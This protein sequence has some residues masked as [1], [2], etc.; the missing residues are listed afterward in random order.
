MSQSYIT[1]ITQIYITQV[2]YTNFKFCKNVTVHSLVVLYKHLQSVLSSTL[3]L[4]GELCLDQ[5][6]TV[7]KCLHS[8]N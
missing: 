3:H 8:A 4:I 5:M 6:S 7:C 1:Q 2:Y